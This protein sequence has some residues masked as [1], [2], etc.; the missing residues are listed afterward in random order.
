MVE[1]TN[2]AKEAIVSIYKL[3]QQRTKNKVCRDLAIQFDAEDKDYK[4]IYDKVEPYL[5]ELT[6]VGF[7]EQDIV[8]NIELLPQGIIWI[9]SMPAKALSRLLEIVSKFI[10]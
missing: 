10:P 7:V 6:S 9:E 8:G 2:G 1:L 4:R 5:D 3:Y